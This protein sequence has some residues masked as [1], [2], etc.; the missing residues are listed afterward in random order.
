MSSSR[1]ANGPGQTRGFYEQRMGFKYRKFDLQDAVAL[2]TPLPTYSSNSEAER[3]FERQLQEKKFKWPWIDNEKPSQVR[4]MI[5]WHLRLYFVSEGAVTIPS[6][7]THQR[8]T[9]EPCSSDVVSTSSGFKYAATELSSPAAA[10]PTTLTAK[11]AAAEL[12]SP[13]AAR[14]TTLTAKHA[15]VE[16]SSSTA[17]RLTTLTASAT[18][19]LTIQDT[20]TEPEA[21]LSEHKSPPPVDPLTSAAQLVGQHKRRVVHDTDSDSDVVAARRKKGL[22][23]KK[24]KFERPQPT[25]PEDTSNDSGLRQKLRAWTFRVTWTTPTDL[26]FR[27]QRNGVNLWIKANTSDFEV[28]AMIRLAALKVPKHVY[29]GSLQPGTRLR[30]NMINLV[31]EGRYT[32]I[33]SK[34]WIPLD[35]AEILAQTLGIESEMKPLVYILSKYHEIAS[36]NDGVQEGSTGFGPIQCGTC[37]RAFSEFKFLNDHIMRS[38]K[39]CELDDPQLLICLCGTA[40]SNT[41]TLYEH[42]EI[43][44]ICK[45]VITEG[46]DE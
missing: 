21:R 46:T 38:S 8:S 26:R 16:L 11:H 2:V 24:R 39:C 28:Y 44:G 15:A 35:R 36:S 40:Y 6:G 37:M 17:A 18:E 13:A 33:G 32:S 29:G 22:Y 3:D 41:E 20:D 9:T 27:A 14:P 31:K 12:S 4:A 23:R 5:R 19:V 30:K 25:P 7:P 34:L 10:R 42:Q 43:C 45:A 1:D